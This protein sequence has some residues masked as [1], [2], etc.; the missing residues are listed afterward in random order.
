MLIPLA[1]TPRDS[2]AAAG[3]LIP[4]KWGLLLCQIGQ[5]YLQKIFRARKIMKNWSRIKNKQHQILCGLGEN[6]VWVNYAVSGPHRI[7][8]GNFFKNWKKRFFLHK[9]SLKRGTSKIFFGKYSWMSPLL[10]P[11]L[12]LPYLFAVWCQ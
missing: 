10:S 9:S 5:R 1:I 3:I 12:V 4:W 11:I 2:E 7:I 8:M 6:S